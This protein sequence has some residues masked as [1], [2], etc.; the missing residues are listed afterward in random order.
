MEW[1]KKLEQSPT[2]KLA[3]YEVDRR[4]VLLTSYI[5]TEIMEKLVK[6]VDELT[7]ECVA[8]SKEIDPGSYGYFFSCFIEWAFRDIQKEINNCKIMTHEQYI[9]YLHDE[10]D[11]KTEK[12]GEKDV[13]SI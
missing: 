8:I 13:H 9:A 11:S 5:K 6:K 1:D 12:E 4:R 3:A 2:L 7:E 10:E